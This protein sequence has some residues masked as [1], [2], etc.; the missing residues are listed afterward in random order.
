MRIA[1]L[2]C[3]SGIS[4]DMFLGA[5]VDAGVP[6]R[7]LEETVAALDVG[8][9]L[10]ISRVDR[11]GIAAT[12]VDVIIGGEKDM[13]REQYW[14][15][16]EVKK[17]HE[18]LTGHTEEHAH[19]HPHA[20]DSTQQGAVSVDAREPQIHHTAAQGHGRGLKEIR[21]IIT[22]A[23]IS[24][25]AKRR[26]TAIFQS[27]GEAEAKVHNAD[28]ETIHFHEVGSVD[29]IVDI[30]CAAVASEALRVD[31]WVCSPLN[32]GGGTVYCSHGTFPVPA[33][34]VVE[35]L[36]DAP[37]YS[38]GLQLELV[39]PTGA[40]IAR[41]LASRFGAFPAM[42]VEKAGYG[43]GSRNFEKHPNVLRLSVGEAIAEADAAGDVSAENGRAA[44]TD[45]VRVI[46]AN[47]DDATPQ[48]LGY[49][50]ERL[51]AAGA[52]DV[53][54]TP[55]QMK[56]SRPGTLL[57][58]LAR[59]ANEANLADILFAESTTLGVRIREERR[60]VL[61]RRTVPVQTP[62]GE[63]RVKVA[64]VGG[65]V[66]NAAPEFEDCRRLAAAHHIPLKQ[67]IQAAMSSWAEAEGNK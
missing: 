18:H 46:E 55:I 52:L 1:Y 48:L 62:W 17:R 6:A 61:E 26:A 28:V 53:F 12:K 5:L 22:A 57:T 47:I 64:H 50:Q 35:L 44:A 59:P 25:S 40:A 20:H 19:D 27:L 54:C 24:D 42:R 9:R 67:V 51:M 60:R 14:R 13:P 21:E 7:L 11:A 2:E 63:V 10:E 30:V 66:R 3:F 37:I 65:E 32:V 43:A 56:K 8:A 36:K 34:A 39:T 41:T 16:R 38:G 45:V 15:E 49:V 33:P 31:E 29:A 4:G 58:V 23:R